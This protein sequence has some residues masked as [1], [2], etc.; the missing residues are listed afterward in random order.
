MQKNENNQDAIDSIIRHA[1]AG[2]SLTGACH[3]FCSFLQ[4][5]PILLSVSKI[6]MSAIST[7]LLYIAYTLQPQNI[8]ECAA[9]FFKPSNRKGETHYFSTNHQYENS[10]TPAWTKV[11]TGRSRLLSLQ[12]KLFNDGER[13]KDLNE[14]ILRQWCR[15]GGLCYNTFAKSMSVG[16]AAY[17]L[18]I[19][20]VAIEEDP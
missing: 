2:L 13:S 1:G 14:Y 9:V 15:P 10:I 8:S 17:D 19:K 6:G 12:G 11:S 4:F 18:G 16:L 5:P 3:I 20:Y 7:P